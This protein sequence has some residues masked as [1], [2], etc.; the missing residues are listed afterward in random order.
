MSFLLPTGK[1][2]SIRGGPV[3]PLVLQFI[4][5]VE[6]GDYLPELR[7]RDLLRLGHGPSRVG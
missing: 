7:V 5:S 4:E 1:S 6:D 2:A 3:K